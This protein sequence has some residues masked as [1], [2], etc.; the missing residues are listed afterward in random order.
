MLAGRIS[1]CKIFL[2]GTEAKESKRE[3]IEKR[4]LLGQIGFTEDESRDLVPARMKCGPES[5]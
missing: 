4:E 3:E 5:A 2:C 1:S